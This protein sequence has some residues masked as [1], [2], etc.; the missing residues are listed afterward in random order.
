MQALPAVETIHE[1][2]RATAAL[3]PMRRRILETLAQPDSATGVARRLGLP[4]QKV[5]YHLRLLEGERLVELQEERR[6]GGCIERVFRPTA[7][8]FVIAPDVLGALAPDPADITDRFSSAYLVAVAGQAIRDLGALE[9]AAR[10]AGKR[11]PTLTVETEVRFA[12]PERQHAFAKELVEALSTLARKYN[13]H[14]APDGRS[15]RFFT[16]GYPARRGSGAPGPKG[17][18]DA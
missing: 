13:D 14:D 4:R 18:E 11:L 5:N 17:D 6:V 16:G 8:A 10:K 15:F 2:A 9:P 3:H 1:G 12:S 7:R